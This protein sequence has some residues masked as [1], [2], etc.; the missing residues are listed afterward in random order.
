[1]NKYADDVAQWL[2]SSGYTTCFFVAGGN[3]MHLIEA[4]SKKLEMIPVIHEVAAAISADYF[5]EASSSSSFKQG[6]ALALVTLGPGAT[7]TLTGVAGAYMDSRELLIIAGQVKSSDLRTVQERQRGIQ[8]IDGVPIFKSI[9]KKSICLNARLDETRFKSLVNFAGI[10]RKGPIYIEICHDVQGS[11]SSNDQDKSN[12]SS[13]TFEKAKTK[14]DTRQAMSELVKKFSSAKRPLILI[15]GGF[16][17]NKPEVLN[18]LESL[19]IPIATTWNA[20]DRISSE[21]RI[22]AGRPNFFGQRW[23]NIILQQSDLIIVLGSSLGLQ[24]TGFNLDE[25]APVADVFQL[26]IENRSFMGSR[27]SKFF[28]AQISIEDFISDYSVDFQS[29]SNSRKL[30]WEEWLG[31]VQ[32]VR[33]ALPLV[34]H[35]TF[36]EDGLINP[37]EFIQFLSVN[38]PNKLNFIPC[39]SGGSYTSSMQVFEQRAN[40]LIISSRGLGS[41]GIGIAGAI[42]AAKANGNV[43]WLIDGDGGILQNIQELATVN[44]LELPIKII[45]LN[46]GGYGSIRSTQRKYFNGN[47]IG[48][49]SATGLGQPNFE[50]LAKAFGIDYLRISNVSQ[51]KPSMDHLTSTKPVLIEV[52]ISQ[53]QP[54]L[55]KID[56]VLNSDG[57]MKSAPLHEMFPPIDK[58]IRL[59][60]LRYLEGSE[61]NREQN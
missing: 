50:F 45:V 40:C 12:F 38:A 43:T 20:A 55:P 23:A 4:F 42:G 28:S 21:S 39:S 9:T 44:Q 47:Y 19:N 13:L 54:F 8:E 18:I 2:K 5:N 41:M 30:D 61:V 11:S 14:V 49:D 22:Y 53:E 6:K 33:E 59:K 60:V 37:F 7:N 51:I 1:M 32:E 10:D 48:C 46:N 35:S 26:D 58:E 27:L 57:S 15:G 56:S 29:I 24:Q 16:G 3:I 17:R 34:E 36:A 52:F 25:F 31:F